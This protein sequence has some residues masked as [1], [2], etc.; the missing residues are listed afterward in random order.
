MDTDLEKRCR[1]LRGPCG[2]RCAVLRLQRAGRGATR[3][4][5]LASACFR[6]LLR[7]LQPSPVP[8]AR[9]PICTAAAR[10]TGG[11]AKYIYYCPAGLG[12]R[13]R[14]RCPTSTGGPCGQPGGRAGGDGQSRRYPARRAART[15]RGRR[16]RP[17]PP[18]LHRPRKVTDSGRGA[19]CRAPAIRRRPAP[20]PGG[21]ASSTSRKSC[22]APST[23]PGRSRLA[24]ENAAVLPH[25]V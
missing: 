12:V 21:Q 23:T 13:R 11:T 16:G 20:Q 22:S 4:F 6:P 1:R 9:T 25:R 10:R 14:P 5:R 8:G 7:G 17:P 2:R 3:T 24:E 15:G 18:V 19:P